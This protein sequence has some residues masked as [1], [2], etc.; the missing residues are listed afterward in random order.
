MDVV[1]A[2]RGREVWRGTSRLAALEHGGIERAVAEVA[3]PRRRAPA[4]RQAAPAPSAPARTSLDIRPRVR[5]ER[6]RARGERAARRARGAARLK[7][8]RGA[9]RHD[10]HGRRAQLAGV[11]HAPRR[12]LPRARRGPSR[13]QLH[14]RLHGRVHAA[15][16]EPADRG[17]PGVLPRGLA[18]GRGRVGARAAPGG[19]RPH[20]RRG[21]G[22]HRRRAAVRLRVPDDRRRRPRPVDLGE[23][24][25]PARR[26]GPAASPST[27]SC[28]TS[29]SCGARRRR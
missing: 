22:V 4:T 9:G 20:R 13:H 8:A 15:L 2:E 18:R 19:S 23:D 11:R 28:S 1:V 6:R 10:D 12:P 26:R 21:R 3:P 25:D 29:P 24:L 14:R 5:A 17:G 16:R 7:R 27:A